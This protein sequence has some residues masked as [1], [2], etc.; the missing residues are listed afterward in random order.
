MIALAEEEKDS[1]PSCG[2]PKAWCRTRDAEE[3]MA[4]FDVAEDRCWATYRIGLRREKH[5][6]EGIH[7]AS[8]EA[9]QLSP[10]FRD[11]HMPPLEAGLDLD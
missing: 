3:G 1:C 5:T 7:P 4:R 9:L 6:S 10:R 2:M 11:G 8:R